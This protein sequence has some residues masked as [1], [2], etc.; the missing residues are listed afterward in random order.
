MDELGLRMPGGTPAGAAALG[1]GLVLGLGFWAGRR[2][3][4]TPGRPARLVAVSDL[5]AAIRAEEE[6]AVVLAHVTRQARRLIGA[7]R[8]LAIAPNL[9]SGVAVAAAD[10]EVGAMDDADALV[11]QLPIARGMTGATPRI[12]PDFLLRHG[13]VALSGAAIVAPLAVAG[14]CLAVVV[15]TARRRS[16]SARDLEMLQP[17]ADA[18]ALALDYA[19]MRKESGGATVLGE[20]ERIAADLHDNVIRTMFGVGMQLQSMAARITDRW[21][22]DRLERAVADVDQAINE[23]REHVF[24]LRSQGR[25]HVG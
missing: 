6:D 5:A 19:R 23:L 12:V 9:G 25:P 15:V 14:R 13:S 2:G 17:F 3:L 18:V 21:L 1:A 10:P 8:A 22:Q 16:F 20:R 11:R 4:I 24:A 7:G